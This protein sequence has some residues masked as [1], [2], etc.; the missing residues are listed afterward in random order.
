MICKNC[1]KESNENSCPVCGQKLATARL[2]LPSMIHNIALGI[3]NCDQGIW[4]TIKALFIWPGYMI[5]EYLEGKRVRYF[6]P[7]VS[8]F[9]TLN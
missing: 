8:Y 4:F 5:L 2:P 6:A 9:K 3:F 7:R 1:G